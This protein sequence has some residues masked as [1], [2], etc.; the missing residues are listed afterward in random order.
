MKQ[1]VA[2]CSV[3]VVVLSC[4]ASAQG[5][6]QDSV[7]ATLDPGHPR[8]MLKDVDLGRLKASYPDDPAL[9]KCWRDVQKQA[10]ACL[11]KGPLVYEKIGPR[12]L[13][14]SRDC[15]DRVYALGLAYRWTGDGK[16]AAKAKENLLEVC[17][18][19]DWN[20]SH[21]LDV[22][23][24]SHAVG[25]GYD[26]LY[27]YLGEPTRDQIRAALIEKGLKPGIEVYDNNGWWVQ[28]EFNWNQVCNG[29]MIVGALAI[30]ETDPSYAERIIPT[31]VKSLPRALASYAPDG[32][33]PEGPAYWSY[34]T[35]YTAY[36]LTALDT[37]LG[38]TF[39]LLDIDGLSKAGYF[40]IYTTGPTGLYLNFADVGEDSARRPMPCMF[41]LAR[42]FHNPLYAWS[43][44]EQIATRPATAAHLVWYTA[45][46]P[47]RA[48]SR[49]LDA[50]F[51]GP[52][53]VV[54]MR[55][56]WDDPNALFVGVKAGYNQVSHGHLDLGNF[57]LDALGVRWARDLGSDNYNLPDYWDKERGGKRWSYYRLNS[58][59][60]NVIMLNGKDQDPLAKS[61][62]S[63]V[64]INT[65]EPTAAVDLT[66]AY[67]E[68]A[69]S[70]VR[71]VTMTQ[72]RQAVL[73]QDDLSVKTPCEVAW[74]V[75]TDARIDIEDGSR[76]VLQFKDKMFI[77]RLLSPRD[78]KFTVESA[79]QQPPQNPNKDVRRLMV[80]LPKAQGDVRVSV[81]FSPGGRKGEPAE[82]RDSASLLC[83]G[84][85]QTEEQG[86][87]QL[88][89]FAATYSTKAE[90]QQRAQRIR[91]GILRGAELWPLPKKCPLNAIIHSRREH[92]GYSVEN[93]AFESLP[94]VF[95]TG[96][97]YV[98]A[99]GSGPFAAILCTHGHW[100]RP[101]DYGRFRPDMQKRCAT[102][103][104]MGA[105][106]F[107]C[108]MVGYGDWANAGWQHKRPGVLKLQLWNNI[109][110]L[111]FLTSRPDV[112]PSRIAVTGASGGGT[113][114]ILL[115]AVDDRIAVSV[116]VVM[117]SAHF[118]GGCVCES[119]MPIHKNRNHETN[120]AE[121]AALAAPRPML[122]IS[123]GKDWTKNVPQ[124]EFP[125]IQ[126][127]YRL[128]GVE[129]RVENL[130]L[131]DEGH[132]YGYSK[133]VGAYRFLAKHFSLS[134]ENVTGPDG[135]VDETPVVVETW[136]TMLVFNAE[137]LRPANAVDPNADLPWNW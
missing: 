63:K 115:T 32:A 82:A 102:L 2:L 90:W 1:W 59:S 79:E 38:N 112:D 123:D 37:A 104:R 16:Y 28:S 3:L 72:G 73:V 17:A 42:T 120:N 117:V 88:A 122:V 80:R 108:D 9:Q 92:D 70:A 99:R 127:I 114:T 21:F 135:R 74:G 136:Q 13:H 97:L 46:P 15:L 67:K 101:D 105:V 110:A 125:Y 77:A 69:N 129:D 61:K 24:M 43:E 54:T 131:P 107:A 94:G 109:R 130:H 25:V 65:A 30:A 53:E 5:T 111:D 132:D 121:I 96:N 100:N 66:E 62:F 4:R 18:F 7:L 60:H 75:T 20:P 36:G 86:K 35:H 116:P 85:Y 39:G 23:E 44:H 26:W 55:S 124:V 118:F 51:K 47:A 22:A 119:G 106:V 50:Y 84:N 33:W 64:E 14:V 95:V 128:C 83:V 71:S 76:A 126:N 68:L 12:L 133:R 29:G 31:A 6:K 49:Q 58:A 91:E 52:V 113:Q 137:H 134:L 87:E 8:L 45:R 10:D 27:G 19:A 98:P 93:A 34:A 56:A 41:W 11:R 40:P 89:R 81:L 57:E 78:A 48:A 103:A